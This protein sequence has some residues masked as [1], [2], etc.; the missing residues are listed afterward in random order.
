MINMVDTTAWGGVVRRGIGC[1]HMMWCFKLQYYNIISDIDMYVESGGED[2]SR[3][4]GSQWGGSCGRWVS[5]WG[6][7]RTRKKVKR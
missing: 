1:C 3:D 6:D 4:D 2:T 7:G 5:E